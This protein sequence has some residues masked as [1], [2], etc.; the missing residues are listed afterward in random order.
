MVEPFQYLAFLWYDF[1]LI[2]LVLSFFLRA[3]HI[4]LV[5]LFFMRIWS[6]SLDRVVGGTS[7]VLFACVEYLFF[8]AKFPFPVADNIN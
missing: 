1:P 4:Y 7:M 6:V 5:C 3:G 2:D 8:E